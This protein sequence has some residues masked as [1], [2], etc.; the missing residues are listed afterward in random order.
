[1]LAAWLITV[2]LQNWVG[3]YRAELSGYPDEPGHY[4]SSLMVRQYL[5]DGWWKQG[6][7]QFAEQYYVH[8]PRVAIGHWPPFLYLLQGVWMLVFPPTI[9]AVLWLQALIQAAVVGLLFWRLRRECGVLVV[10][11][12]SLVYLLLPESQRLNSQVMAEPLLGFLGLLGVLLLEQF[13]RQH[14]WRWLAGFAV[15]ACCT[16]FTKGSGLALLPV[17]FF[18]LVAIQ[19]WNLL[20]NW[21]FWAAHVAIV[22][23][24]APWLI[25]TWKM[26]SNGMV[27]GPLAGVIWQQTVGFLVMPASL[28]GVP[29]AG[30]ALVSGWMNMWDSKRGMLGLIGTITAASIL[31]FHCISPTGVE[32]RR[33]YMLIP[34]LL[35]L[36]AW[37]AAVAPWRRWALVGVSLLSLGM[38]YD[39]VD[40]AAT[41]YREV[42]HWLD[43]QVGDRAQAVFLSTSYFSE[44]M[45]ISEMAQL[46]AEPHM[47]L[48]RGSK[49]L[50]DSDWNGSGYRMRLQSVEELEELLGQVPVRLIVSEQFQEGNLLPHVHLVEKMIE[51]YPE[52]WVLR[53]EFAMFNNLSGKHGQAR[54]YEH[55]GSEN[56]EVTRLRVD[57]TRMLDR[58]V[59]P[60]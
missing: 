9:A 15:L 7:M 52:Q 31:V 36:M 23:S 30:I 4:V 24:Y 26:A 33:L 10:S 45:L 50:S 32:T 1:M 55:L 39:K 19:A 57:L 13:L 34:V 28:M 58:W 2:S 18:V 54:V 44:G 11:V 40:K 47:F 29:L 25:Y 37:W 51:R 16:V 12:L 60:R 21:R 49:L 17:P 8:Y 42:A 56:K 6:P 59:E 48:V 20:R 3:A 38:V 46:K 43:G 41:G 53:K 22:A 35:L 5:L 27:T 14:R